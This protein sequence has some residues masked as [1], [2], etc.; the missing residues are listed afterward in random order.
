MIDY[1]RILDDGIVLKRLLWT[2]KMDEKLELETMVCFLERHRSSLIPK[3]FL[4]W[5]FDAHEGDGG[6]NRK[7]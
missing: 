5:I 4:A 6:S 1:G 3:R 2:M 7:A